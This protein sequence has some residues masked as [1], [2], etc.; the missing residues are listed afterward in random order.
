M[1][2]TKE[3]LRGDAAW[4]AERQ[5][6]AK[7]NEA[8]HARGRQQRAEKEALAAQRDRAA[9]RREMASL[10]TQPVRPPDSKS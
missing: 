4:Q 10:P 6:I 9:T 5:R 8:A 7:N 2:E 1:S 3:P